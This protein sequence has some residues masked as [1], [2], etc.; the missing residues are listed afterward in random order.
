[1]RAVAETREL[2]HRLTD[3]HPEL[4]EGV[5]VKAVLLAIADE[6]EG[7]ARDTR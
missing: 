3:R 2:L 4:R 7:E 5:T 6:I 1:M